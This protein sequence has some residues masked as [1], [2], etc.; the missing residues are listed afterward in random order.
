MIYDLK[1]KSF[2][3]CWFS[4]Q[5]NRYKSATAETLTICIGTDHIGWQ[6]ISPHRGSNTRYIPQNKFQAV[7]VVIT[8]T[9]QHYA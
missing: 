9:G 5:N 4:H 3:L 6:K 2:S 1:V 8:G 7:G